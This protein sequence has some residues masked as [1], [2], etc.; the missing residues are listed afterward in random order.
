[1]NNSY[2]LKNAYM[3]FDTKAESNKQKYKFNNINSWKEVS[4]GNDMKRPILRFFDEKG[5]ILFDAEY[6]ILST[7]YSLDNTKDEFL[8]VW[9]W[10][11]PQLDKNRTMLCRDLLKYGLDITSSDNF[12]NLFMK[13]L[14]TNSRL[15][16]S[17]IEMELIVALSFYLSKKE[18]VITLNSNQGN[19][20]FKYWTILT[21][22]INKV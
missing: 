15:K 13:S 1:M 20:T 9:A 12:M 18:A 6:E 19:M 2:I 5:N 8:W 4:S 22:I 7:E 16:V 21:K 14:F 10:A 11:N 17:S 3:Y